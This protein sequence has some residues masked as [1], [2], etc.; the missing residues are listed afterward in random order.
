MVA[1]AI[2]STAKLSQMCF[3]DYNYMVMNNKNKMSKDYM[4]CLGWTKER[5][6]LNKINYERNFL[7]VSSFLNS[8]TGPKQI[9]E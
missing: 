3:R 6:K 7:K 5:K 8:G 4:L 2:R 1:F 9:L